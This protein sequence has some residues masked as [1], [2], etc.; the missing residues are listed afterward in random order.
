MPQHQGRPRISGDGRKKAKHTRSSFSNQHKLEVAQHLITYKDVKETLRHF[1]PKLSGDAKEQRRMKYVREPG[2]AT[3]LPRAAEAAIV[4]WVNL[5]RKD[6][7]PVS[8]T[9]LRLKGAK[10]AEDLGVEAFEGSLHWRKGFLRRHR[11]SIRARE[12]TQAFKFKPPSRTTVCEWVCSNWAKLSASTIMNGF[13][14]AHILA[15]IPVCEAPE[16]NLQQPEVDAIT[17]HELRLIDSFVSD[18]S[19]DD[20]LSFSD[21]EAD[22]DDVDISL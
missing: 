7:V 8:A 21:T 11:L 22:T 13:R 17:E 18:V 12:H 14:K 20:E 10:V 16:S 2:V 3:I 4:Q 9:M 15:P 6:G 5:L 19:S 1:Y